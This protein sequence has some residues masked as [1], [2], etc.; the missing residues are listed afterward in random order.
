MSNIELGSKA[1]EVIHLQHLVMHV[2]SMLPV[3]VAW[4]S[5]S[6]NPVISLEDVMLGYF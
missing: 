5:T 1:M 6:D 3:L 2:E 4:G